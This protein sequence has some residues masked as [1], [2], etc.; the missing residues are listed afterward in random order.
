M[1]KK[2]LVLTIAAVILISLCACR[3]KDR[4]IGKWTMTV[5][6]TTISREFKED[7][8]I[9][10]ITDDYPFLRAEGVYT[11]DGN[12]ISIVMTEITNEE[13]GKSLP[14]DT[15]WEFTYRFKDGDLLLIDVGNNDTNEITYT[16]VRE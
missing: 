12:R 13:M 15:K 4:L 1:I 10:E 3:K 7:G 14:A 16:R 8:T 6:G 5:N 2:I 9:I 11:V